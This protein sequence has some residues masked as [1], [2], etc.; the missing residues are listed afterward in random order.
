M[1]PHFCLGWRRYARDILLGHIVTLEK[2]S[3]F[4]AGSMSILLIRSR[5][6]PSTTKW[7]KPSTK[8]LPGLQMMSSIALPARRHVTVDE[9]NDEPE[10]RD[11]QTGRH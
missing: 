8:T 7:R 10:G 1:T 4:Y 11:F 5:V 2:G 9:D 3:Q 6:T